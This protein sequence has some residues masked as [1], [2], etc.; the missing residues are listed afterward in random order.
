MDT[1]PLHTFNGTEIKVS[2]P[3][4]QGQTKPL[5]LHRPC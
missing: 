3:P 1:L 2:I 5:A 4:P